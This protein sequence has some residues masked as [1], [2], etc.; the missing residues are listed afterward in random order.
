MAAA[1]N[2]FFRVI[3]LLAICSEIKRYYIACQ[4]FV[5]TTLFWNSFQAVLPSGNVSRIR[6]K[7][8]SNW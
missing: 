8:P 1:S 6:V 5:Q 4:F 7:I 2:S 3:I